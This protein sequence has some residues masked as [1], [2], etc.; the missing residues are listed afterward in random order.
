[1]SMDAAADRGYVYL[2]WTDEIIRLR[3]ALPPVTSAERAIT[4][5]MNRREALQ[6]ALRN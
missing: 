1:M 6:R 4:D 5:R 2:A 3:K